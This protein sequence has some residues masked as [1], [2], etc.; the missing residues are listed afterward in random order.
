MKEKKKEVE[1]KYQKL[2]SK[3]LTFSFSRVKQ[4]ELVFPVG[5]RLGIELLKI[6]VKVR[7]ELLHAII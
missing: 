7:N 3:S 1:I 4:R 5:R 2:E 6:D